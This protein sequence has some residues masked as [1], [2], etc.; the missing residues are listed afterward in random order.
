MQRCG[1]ERLT[2]KMSNTQNLR[3]DVWNYFSRDLARGISTCNTCKANLKTPP[4]CSTK[5]LH[6]HLQSKHK[7]STVKLSAETKS[8]PHDT[9]SDTND[10]VDL[11]QSVAPVSKKARLHNYFCNVS[12]NSTSAVI[13]RMVA[14]DG[15]PFRAFI[16][17]TDLRRL[18]LAEGH[19]D[20]PKSAN[21]V[22]NMVQQHAGKVRSVIVSELKAH[23]KN[24]KRFSLTFDEGSSVRNRRYMVI[25]VHDESQYWSLGLVRVS[26]SMPADKC[27]EL[28][29]QR[30]QEFGLS[31]ENHIVAICTDGASVMCKVGRLMSAEH[32]VCLAHG[33]HLAVLDVLYKGR[34]GAPARAVARTIPAAAAE[35]AVELEDETEG[36][37][38]NDPPSNIDGDSSHSDSETEI[39]ETNDND[40]EEAEDQFE[41]S[42]QSEDNIAQLSTEYKETI[43]RV[44]KIVKLF[45]KSPT[46]NDSILQKYVMEEHKKELGL[47]LD[48]PTRWN[49]LLAMLKRFALLRT[50]IQKAMIDVLATNRRTV[51]ITDSDF[52]VVNDLVSTLEPVALVIEVLSRRDTNL[53]SAEAALQFCVVQLRKQASELAKTMADAL[54][55]RITERYAS[56][57][58][59]LRYLHY[60][61]V[62]I[63][64]CEF[65]DAMG[66]AQLKKFILRL[67]MRLTKPTSTTASDSAT[68]QTSQQPQHSG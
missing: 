7:I 53:I 4:G 62:E 22:N 34:D 26:G 59:V 36:D 12:D 3:S 27:I 30:L 41:I 9:E 35:S 65:G 13:A 10:N 64:S 60:G 21:T 66:T 68:L 15:L 61:V 32:Q 14:C 56:H 39:E 55:S 49:S 58:K 43:D 29:S 46:K 67:L 25:N 6:T 23:V 52:H 16:S 19:F 51:Q 63:E 38:G 37:Q 44:R 1:N 33:I 42:E 40:I 45:R 57:S 31:L 24:G 28:V 20:L 54:H 2:T 48:C 17:S 11:D 5:S 47:I 50:A 8:K 18:M